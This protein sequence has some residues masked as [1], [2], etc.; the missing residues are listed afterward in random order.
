MSTMLW[1]LPLLLACRD[2]ATDVKTS[3][4]TEPAPTTDTSTGVSTDTP[5]DERFQPLVDQLLLD[6]AENDAPGV[7][8]AVMEGGVVTFAAG[9]GSARPDAEAP[10]TTDTLFQL[11][12]TTK[13][14][15]AVAVL[16]EVEAGRLS[17][18]QTVDTLVPELEPAA[19]PGSF[20]QMTVRHLLTHQGGFYDALDWSDSPDDAYLAEWLESYADTYWLMAD[21][22]VFFNYSNPN[23]SVAGR[24]LEVV[25][26]EG[27]P[28]AE[29]VESEVF[30]P[31][32]M[33]RTTFSK[34]QARTDGDY[35][36]GVGYDI[37]RQGRATYGDLTMLMIDDN[38]SSRPA[39]GCTWSTPTELLQMASFLMA[40]D[41]G[42]L[43]DALRQQLVSAQVSTLGPLDDAYG[44][45]L[46][47]TPGFSLSDGYH[48]VELWTHGG[49]TLGYTSDFYVVPSEGFAISIMSSGYGQDFTPSVATALET[50]LDVGPP[51]AA[52]E[53][54][55][56][57]ARLDDHVGT[58]EDVVNGAFTI[59]REGDGLTIDWPLLAAYDYEVAPELVPISDAYWLLEI[60][61]V[62]YD[63][64]FVGEPGTPSDYAAN[65]IFVGRR[66]EEGKVSVSLPP[67]PVLPE[68]VMRISPLRRF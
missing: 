67:P 46:F 32:G 58:Y 48:D 4:E 42:V 15:T 19:N 56:D 24:L 43:D 12:S 10:V 9:F 38:A 20:S 23:W 1:T 17:L 2:G 31:L 66:A 28:Y 30:R 62:P 49:N 13:M 25:D 6:L 11:G 5:I 40:G 22:G 55:F 39:G 60:D 36:L 3:R 57:P 35:A 44:Y 50:L 47:V 59:E 52:P 18:D 21:P 41:P 64:T 63:L 7:S 61:G 51:V 37:D 45:G 33:E 68:P 26:P 34:A 29:R 54:P 14:F 16:Q 53:V 65:R 8:V 27:R